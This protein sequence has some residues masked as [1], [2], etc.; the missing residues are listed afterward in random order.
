MAFVSSDLISSGRVAAE[1]KARLP[2]HLQR[3]VDVSSEKGASSWLSVLPIIEHG[4]ALQ[5]GALISCEVDFM[6][7]EN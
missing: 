6:R 4:F 2:S 7:I 5:K 3:A 1:A